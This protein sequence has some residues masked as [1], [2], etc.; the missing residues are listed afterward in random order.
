MPGASS[1]SHA[2]S[3]ASRW[4]HQGA[5]ASIR[6]GANKR[7][8][9]QRRLAVQ[10]CAFAATATTAV[11]AYDRFR[12][13]KGQPSLV[14]EFK[15]LLS[16]ALKLNAPLRRGADDD[17]E[18]DQ[19]ALAGL[20]SLPIASMSLA[21]VTAG[22][23]DSLDSAVEPRT[24]LK[25]PLKVPLQTSILGSPREFKD[26]VAL[27]EWGVNKLCAQKYMQTATQVGHCEGA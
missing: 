14:D 5:G 8:A 1:F 10:T 11:V 9:A 16:D 12:Q 21:G 2:W 26:M 25:F 20:P 18:G 3:N 4:L 19:Q 6:S 23:A 22:A 17:D 27:G 15:S 13:S 7:A 24:G